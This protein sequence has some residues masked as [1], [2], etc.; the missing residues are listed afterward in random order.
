VPVVLRF[1]QT[2]VLPD[3]FAGIQPSTTFIKILGTPMGA[4]REVIDNT[5]LTM[6]NYVKI[7]SLIL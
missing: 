4:D 6:D 7:I 1:Q 2:P 5:A 3:E